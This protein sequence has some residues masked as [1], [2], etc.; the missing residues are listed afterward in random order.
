MRPSMRSCGAKSCPRYSHGVPSIINGGI[1]R[2][3]WGQSQPGGR[4]PP[5]FRVYRPANGRPLAGLQA[6][7]EEQFRRGRTD[8]LLRANDGL[9]NVLAANGRA[10]DRPLPAPGTGWARWVAAYPAVDLAKTP[11]F[12]PYQGAAPPGRMLLGSR[13]AWR[14]QRG[15]GQATV[16]NVSELTQGPELDNLCRA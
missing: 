6:T 9:S 5:L 12:Y 4:P 2:Q 13:P 10:G 3:F 1:S 15:A 11:G 14:A 8:G 16:L 7:G